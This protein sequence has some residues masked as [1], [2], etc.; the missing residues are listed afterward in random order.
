MRNWEVRELSSVLQQWLKVQELTLPL[1]TQLVS[2]RAGLQFYLL[3]TMPVPVSAVELS[4]QEL[5]GL[6]HSAR[7]VPLGFWAASSSWKFSG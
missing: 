1:A 4:E 3:M 6:I 5:H 7:T 2:G